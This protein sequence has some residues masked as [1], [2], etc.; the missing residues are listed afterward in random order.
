MANTAYEIE[1]ILDEEIIDEKPHYLIKWKGYSSVEATWEPI[2]NLIDTLDLVHEWK[3]KNGARTTR[4]EKLIDEGKQDKEL[5][6]TKKISGKDHDRM[7]REFQAK[8]NLQ[9]TR[10]RKVKCQSSD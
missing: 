6:K 1:R 7:E 3:V 9:S 5:Q 10:K 8:L 4:P 2:E